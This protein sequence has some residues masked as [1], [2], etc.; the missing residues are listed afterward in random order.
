MDKELN[1]IYNKNFKQLVDLTNIRAHATT[2]ALRNLLLICSPLFGVLVVLKPLNA[3]HIQNLLMNL[4]I[5]CLLFC[6]LLA[7]IALILELKYITVH[8][9]K[10][11]EELQLSIR[12]KKKPEEVLAGNYK[13]ILILTFLAFSFFIISLIIL[14]ISIFIF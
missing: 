6:V 12:N 10:F 3:P 13:L 14:A 7:S 9:K 4:S 8:H 11:Q 5:L 1:E 2:S